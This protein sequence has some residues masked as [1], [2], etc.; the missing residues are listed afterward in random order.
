MLLKLSNPK[1]LTDVIGIISELVTEVRIK[2]NKEGLSIVAIDPANVSL[3]SFILPSTSFSEFDVTEQEV[4]CVNL[5]N[6][7]SILK[8]YKSGN[9]IMKTS[10]DKLIIEIESKTKRIFEIALIDINEEEKAVPP[11]EFNV[12]IEMN[13]DDFYEAIEDCKVVGDVCDFLAKNENFIIEAKGLHSAKSEF[14]N[15]EIKIK[16]EGKARYSLEY[17]QKFIKSCKI[18]DKVLINF[19]DDYP[20][21]LEFVAKNFN[22]VFILAPRTEIED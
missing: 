21:K 13:N 15:Q 4:V 2:I 8:R 6:L 17:L 7:K 18:S 16:G 5:E 3:V 9:L 14:S 22:L 11:L 20:L 19:S 12:E 10:E 1:S